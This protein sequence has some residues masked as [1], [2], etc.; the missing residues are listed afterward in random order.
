MIDAAAKSSQTKRSSTPGS[1]KEL[2]LV[3]VLFVL[4]KTWFG[5]KLLYLAG[6]EQM[7]ILEKF[8]HLVRN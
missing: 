3:E 5:K 4:P 1:C 7:P 8:F 2:R 6:R